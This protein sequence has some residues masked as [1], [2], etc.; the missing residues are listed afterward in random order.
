MN[1]IVNG[2]HRGEEFWKSKG[3][4]TLCSPKQSERTLRNKTVRLQQIPREPSVG[5]GYPV[6]NGLCFRVTNRLMREQREGVRRVAGRPV[7]EHLRDIS[8]DSGLHWAQRS[9]IDA[10][11]HGRFLEA[12]AADPEN[13]TALPCCTC[14]SLIERVIRLRHSFEGEFLLHDPAVKPTHLAP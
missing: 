9:G 12:K 14:H 1:T 2:D 8:A 4:Y 6:L 7:A 10:D 5:M 13:G 3:Q 11:V